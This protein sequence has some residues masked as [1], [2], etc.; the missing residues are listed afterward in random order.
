MADGE[1]ITEEGTVFPIAEGVKRWI[2]PYRI[3]YEGFYS[4]TR[5]GL[6]DRESNRNRGNFH[7][8]YPALLEPQD[9]IFA[10][11]TEANIQRNQSGSQ[12]MNTDDHT[13]Y[14]VHLADNALPFSGTWESPWRVIIIG[15]LADIVEST[16]V[17]DVSEPSVVSDT[18]WIKPGPVSWI[19]WAYN[20]G[21]N[22][23]QIVKK[24]IDLAEEMNWPYNLI[25]W[26]WNEMGNGGDV[27]DAIQYAKEKGIKTLL[28][29]NS[30]TSWN[31]EG[32]PGPLYM[33]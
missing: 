7:W 23:Y 28:W 11:I 29:Y 14:R 5:S 13:M 12:L 24:Y 6:P 16:L 4:L 8:T 3:D 15:S 18:D 22:D 27:K 30:S 21:S 1:Q 33:F 17:T 9:S 20:N 31:G 10:L 25:D 32:A 26:K 19:Y 2:Q